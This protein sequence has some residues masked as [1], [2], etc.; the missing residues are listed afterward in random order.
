[1]ENLEHCT[2]SPDDNGSNI[3]DQESQNYFF[4]EKNT[5]RALDG[6]NL[7]L[8]SKSTWDWWGKAAVVR[9]SWRCP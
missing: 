9:A 3:R 4:L 7:S 8:P 2:T 5:V 1:M 6:V